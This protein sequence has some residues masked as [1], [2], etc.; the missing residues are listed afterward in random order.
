MTLYY[1]YFR[2]RHPL[3]V[4]WLA[5]SVLA[6]TFHNDLDLGRRV[7]THSSTPGAGPSCV[8][9]WRSAERRSVRGQRSHD[10]D[11]GT[12]RQRSI[13][14]LWT[15]LKW[16][17]HVVIMR[18]LFTVLLS[19]LRNVLSLYNMDFWHVN[20]RLIINKLKHVLL[21]LNLGFF[22]FVFLSYN[23]LYYAW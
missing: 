18:N 4:T 5:A 16:W 17:F 14:S 12:I 1:N 13:V 20:C 2:W 6:V 10:V 11:G 3:R 15:C 8:W 22:V 19:L 9:M 23:W 7:T 21:M